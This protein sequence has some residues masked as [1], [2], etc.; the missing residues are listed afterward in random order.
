MGVVGRGDREKRVDFSAVELDDG[1]PVEDDVQ[2]L[3]GTR[4]ELIGRIRKSGKRSGDRERRR[5]GQPL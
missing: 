2:L 1:N 5:H 4:R 3:E